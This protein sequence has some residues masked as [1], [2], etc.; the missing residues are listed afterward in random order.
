MVALSTVVIKIRFKVGVI[1]DSS[2]DRSA[3]FPSG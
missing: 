2:S 3:L 1:V